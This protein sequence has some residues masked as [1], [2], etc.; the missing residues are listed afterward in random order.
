MEGKNCFRT[1][2]SQGAFYTGG[3][4]SVLRVEC[5]EAKEVS[6][7]ATTHDVLVTPCENAVHLVDMTSGASL[8][9]FETPLD[10]D[11]ILHVDTIFCEGSEEAKRN[12]DAFVARGSYV[13]FSTRSLQ[14][15]FLEVIRDSPDDFRF[16]LIKSWVASTYA[17][18][19]V[20][21][22][23]NGLLLLTGCTDGTVRVWNVF[24]HHVTHQIKTPPGVITSFAFN[25]TMSLLA[26][27]NFEGYITILHMGKKQVVASHRSHTSAVEAIHLRSESTRCCVSMGRDRR[28][29]F[30]A[31]DMTV[32]GKDKVTVSLENFQNVVVKEFV[33]CAIF[34]YDGSHVFLGSTDG[35]VAAYKIGG[36]EGARLVC[37]SARPAG[38]KIDD[39]DEE[40]AVRSIVV[41]P[42]VARDS[43]ILF[44]DSSPKDP[45]VRLTAANAAFHINSYAQVPSSKELLLHATLMGFLDQILDIKLFPSAT[46]QD[47]SRIV[48][49]NSKE[50]RVFRGL[51]SLSTAALCGHTDVVMCCAISTCGTLVMTGSKDCTVRFWSVTDST[52]VLHGKSHESEITAVTFNCKQSDSF[53]M[54][55]SVGADGHLRLWDV[56]D[57][58]VNSNANASHSMEPKFSVNAAH[59]SAIHCVAVAPNDQFIA[60]GGKD[61]VTHV[62]SLQGKRCFKEASLKGHKRGVTA[63]AF[64]PTDRVLVSASNDASVRLWSLVSFACVKTMQSDK[65]SIVQLA[66]FNKGTQLV[67]A[68]AEGVLRF[69]A[70]AASDAVAST[71]THTEKVW[72]LCVLETDSE[73]YTVS[74]GADGLLAITEDYT[75]AE[76]QRL[77]EERTTA[78]YHEQELTNA[79]RK[80]EFAAAFRLALE[81]NHPRHL[82]QVLAK[83]IAVDEEGCSSELQRVILRSLCKDETKKLLHF[84]REWLSNARHCVAASIVVESFLVAYRYD[85]ILKMGDVFRGLMEALLSYST[86]HATRLRQSLQR[87]YYLDFLLRSIGGRDFTCST[88]PHYVSI[89]DAS[90]A[91]TRKRHREDDAQ[92]PQ[93]SE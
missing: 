40:Y 30:S 22:S 71:E 84:T 55:V 12:T 85:E 27:G 31:I 21:F 72:G 6:Q 35:V 60:T 25:E 16:K 5:T 87:T 29:S 76:A 3:P 24:H 44:A 82:R 63:V 47:F 90:A 33:S 57:H 52:C 59:S 4:I 58:I 39:I 92:Q 61:K 75:A 79:M 1:K 26:V 91:N 80:G 89:S 9:K 11:V 7:Q 34:D 65:V 64:S 69:W 66:F 88:A 23:D 49:T 41:R 46:P 93:S 53:H 83:W 17:V 78:I 8:A 56:K 45:V 54:A 13:A 15:Y 77:D 14:L 50:A 36:P 70:L 62:W 81:L 86:R 68:N 51:G 37:R 28:L 2:W 19:L 20:K 32:D 42:L 67:T 18:S 74:G 73:T 38:A 10:D 43:G 48:V